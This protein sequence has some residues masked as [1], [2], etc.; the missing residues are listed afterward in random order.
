MKLYRKMTPDADG[1]PVVGSRRNMLGV[2]PRNPANPGFRADVNATAETD[3]VGPGEG[4]S[5]YDSADAIHPHIRGV[6]YAIDADDLPASLMPVQRGRD[7]FH[8]QIE[9]ARAMTLGQF[10]ALLADTRD[11]WEPEQGGGA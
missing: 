7:A 5:V 2:R 1:L 4:L 6:L 9:P 8:Y 3:P 11:S 10:Q